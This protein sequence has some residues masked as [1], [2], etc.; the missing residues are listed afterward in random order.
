MLLV[1]QLQ[2]VRSL[3]RFLHC[4]SVMPLSADV[5]GPAV[6]GGRQPVVPDIP[7]DRQLVVLGGAGRG[8]WMVARS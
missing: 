7:G 3:Q 5:P 2:V 6:V 1:A 4:L 8:D